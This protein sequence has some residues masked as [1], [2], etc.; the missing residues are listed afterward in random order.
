MTRTTR[1]SALG[2]ARAVALLARISPAA[3]SGIARSP[4][5][6]AVDAAA[7]ATTVQSAAAP[8][9]RRALRTVANVVERLQAGF[10]ERSSRAYRRIRD[11][12]SEHLPR[13]NEPA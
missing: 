1:A 7:S 8:V 11:R 3:G 13:T 9:M 2:A 5:A 12:L 6:R 10:V 4:P